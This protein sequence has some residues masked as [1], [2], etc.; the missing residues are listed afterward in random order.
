MGVPNLSKATSQIPDSYGIITEEGYLVIRNIKTGKLM[1]A[2]KTEF[3]QCKTLCIDMNALLHDAINEWV[4]NGNSCYRNDDLFAIIAE[5]INLLLQLTKATILFIGIDGPAPLAKI[6]QQRTR[7]CVKG[8]NDV[9]IGKPNSLMITPGTEIMDEIDIGLKRIISELSG[10]EVI[11]S[12]H[13]IPAEG[14]HKIMAFIKDRRLSLDTCAVFSPD[15]DFTF[16][17]CMLPNDIF[18]L[19]KIVSKPNKKGVIEKSLTFKYNVPI[20]NYILKHITGEN[21][22]HNEMNI[23]IILDFIGLISLGENDFMPHMNKAHFIENDYFHALLAIY[24]T[25]LK[26]EHGN[27]FTESANGRTI[28]VNRSVIISIITHLINESILFEKQVKD[29][30]N[31]SYWEP[32]EIPEVFRKPEDVTDKLAAISNKAVKY[33]ANYFWGEPVSEDIITDMCRQYIKAMLFVLKYY[34][35]SNPP[36]W[37][38]YYPYPCAPRP[39]D[40]LEYLSICSDADLCFESDDTRP[41]DSNIVQALVFPIDTIITLEYLN[42]LMSILMPNSEISSAY[43]SSVYVLQ[44]DTNCQLWQCHACF[45]YP[46][47]FPLA[48]QLLKDGIGDAIYSSHGCDAAVVHYLPTPSM[49]DSAMV[50]SAMMDPHRL[51]LLERFKSRPVELE[52]IL[53]NNTNCSIVTVDQFTAV[54]IILEVP[55]FPSYRGRNSAPNGTENITKYQDRVLKASTGLN[56]YTSIYTIYVKRYMPNGDK[57]DFGGWD[58]NTNQM[59]PISDKLSIIVKILNS[60]QTEIYLLDSNELF[61]NQKYKLS[62][63]SELKV[64]GS[65]LKEVSG[66]ELKEV[67]GSELKVLGSELKKVSGLVYSIITEFNT[68]NGCN[69]P[70]CSNNYWGLSQKNQGYKCENPHCKCSH[71]LYFQEHNTIWLGEDINVLRCLECLPACT[72]CNIIICRLFAKTSECANGNDCEYVHFTEEGEC[73][74]CVTNKGVGCVTVRKEVNK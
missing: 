39:E 8:N 48:I 6:A 7:R 17:A 12:N 37:E 11:Y 56:S 14:E 52:S 27:A 19:S 47:N 34:K 20:R 24:S 69:I 30:T 65:E 61:T 57:P 33:Y 74:K 73:D 25:L 5:K 1:Y 60:P 72:R 49:V 3:N 18:I 54:I 35:D 31:K 59:T 42:T 66:P 46:M 9:I 62:S 43:S 50:D 2:M 70:I 13:K 32:V 68:C 29:T 22:V 15:S 16:L 41:F 55:K 51:Y 36:S 64:S 26:S 40:L 63:G 21:Y 23:A 58:T 45:Q 67:S 71:M 53:L 38:F 28:S 44:D 4:P 10:I